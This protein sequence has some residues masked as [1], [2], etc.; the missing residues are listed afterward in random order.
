LVDPV[1]CD[2]RRVIVRNNPSKSTPTTTT[3][4]AISKPIRVVWDGHYDTWPTTATTTTT[5]G[6]DDLEDAVL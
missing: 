3:T 4:A 2:G 1:H 6:W 5:T